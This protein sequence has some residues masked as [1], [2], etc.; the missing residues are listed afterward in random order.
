VRLAALA[1][2]PEGP[3]RDY[4]AHP[5]PAPATSAEELPLLA[6]D[7]ET[8]GLDPAND[9]VLSLG[10]VPVDGL[11]VRL[12]GA[13]RLVVRGAREVGRSATVH[14][15]T[16]DAVAAGVPLA[17]AL[18]VLLGS[19]SGRVLLAHHAALERGFLAA[20]CRRVHGRDL[21]VVAVDT[22]AL[23]ERALRGRGDLLAGHAWGHDEARASVRLAA[24]RERRG[25]P[26]YASHEAL[27]DALGCA[28]L[29]LAQVAA[30]R[31]GGRT[32]TL[33]DLT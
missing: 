4:L 25:L 17:D 20:A 15:L 3:L 21:P 33:R 7:L 23:E 32:V 31:E 8:T 13:R 29:Y 22:L 12:S 16:D 18:A 9:E 5:F 19:L 27:T 1:A 6:V 26:R 2:A 30:L 28:E 14:G 10:L 24:A 11:R